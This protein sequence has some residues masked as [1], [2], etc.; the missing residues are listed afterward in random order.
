MPGQIPQELSCFSAGP[1]LTRLLPRGLQPLSPT[2]YCLS[3]IC[4]LSSAVPPPWN[5]ATS[6]LLSPTLYD[7]TALQGTSKGHLI[8]ESLGWWSSSPA[9]FQQR[10]IRPCQSRKYT[11]VLWLF[12]NCY[13]TSFT[14]GSLV[15]SDEHRQWACMYGDV[16]EIAPCYYSVQGR[17]KAS[18]LKITLLKYM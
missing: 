13:E 6:C 4:T 5:S 7:S 12:P 9:E 8:N 18:L 17:A 10:S 1:F 14:S 3:F 11:I 15:S 2:N 16:T